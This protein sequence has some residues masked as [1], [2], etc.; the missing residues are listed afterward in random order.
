MRLSSIDRFKTLVYTKQDM[1]DLKMGRPVDF[2]KISQ[3][4]LA[5]RADVHPSF[6]NHL[7]AGRRTDCTPEVAERISEVF[8]LDVTV[9]FDP[10]ESPAMRRSA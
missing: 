1:E 6:I 8:G 3:R 10:E 5:K 4:K 7:V 9:L 2:R